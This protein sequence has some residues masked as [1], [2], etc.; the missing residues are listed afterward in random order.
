MAK[1]SYT[2][3]IGGKIPE[4]PFIKLQFIQRKTQSSGQCSWLLI[5]CPGFYF[6]KDSHVDKILLI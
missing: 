1:E 3:V 4:S 5:R 2:H 6:S